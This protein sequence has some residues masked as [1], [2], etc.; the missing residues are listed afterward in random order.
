[1]R[2]SADW[3]AG[4]DSE[5][6]ARDERMSS[7]RSNDLSQFTRGPAID[8]PRGKLLLCYAPPVV[9]GAASFAFIRSSVRPSR[10]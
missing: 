3:S 2:Y 5:A 4:G 8:T 9:K 7:H 10:T 6:A 1:M